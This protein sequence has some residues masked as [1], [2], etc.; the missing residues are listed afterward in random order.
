MQDSSRDGPGCPL[1]LG[2]CERTWQMLTYSST[3][4]CREPVRLRRTRNRIRPRPRASPRPA[5]PRCA[6]SRIAMDISLLSRNGF[7]PLRQATL[8]PAG[9]CIVKK[10]IRRRKAFAIRVAD[11]SV[12]LMP[13]SLG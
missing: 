11:Y 13:G 5:S 3:G 6:E 8:R 2:F 4:Y 9:A 7:T 12:F 10:T 1:K